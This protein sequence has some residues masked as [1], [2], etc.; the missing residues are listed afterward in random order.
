MTRG[1][2][3]IILSVLDSNKPKTRASE[4]TQLQT[5]E[6]APAVRSSVRQQRNTT[7]RVRSNSR[8]PQIKRPGTISQARSKRRSSSNTQP[9]NIPYDKPSNN[10]TP[11]SHTESVVFDFFDR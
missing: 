5:K 7:P 8:A 3:T 6:T 4:T 10:A 11:K 9:I 2:E 1:E